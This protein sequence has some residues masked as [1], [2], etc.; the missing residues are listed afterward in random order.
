MGSRHDVRDNPGQHRDLPCTGLV[1]A[2]KVPPG[3]HRKEERGASGTCPR[4][5]RDP[6]GGVRVVSRSRPPPGSI[7]SGCRSTRSIATTKTAGRAGLPLR[8]VR[9]RGRP[10]KS[11]I[12]APAWRPGGSVPPADQLPVFTEVAVVTLGQRSVA[13][14]VLGGLCDCRPVTRR[15][16][17]VRPRPSTYHEPLRVADR[18]LGRGPHPAQRCRVPHARHCNGRVA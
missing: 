11:A 6:G 2:T 16:W 8:R 9:Q 18:L 15:R 14:A 12:R 1:S 3:C 5:K 7:L 10:G 4:L 13:V 17:R